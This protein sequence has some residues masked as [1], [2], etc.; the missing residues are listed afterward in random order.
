M[1]VINT[2]DGDTNA[3]WE[4][5]AGLDDLLVVRDLLVDLGGG[6]WHVHSDVELGDGD[7]KA[8]VVEELE[9]GLVVWDGA[10]A[11]DQVRLGSNTVDWDT[12][13]L[14]AVD[15]GDE[16]GEL[17]GGVV[18]VVVVEVEL[19]VWIGLG[20]GTESNLNG[21]LTEEAVEDGVTVVS[22]VLEDLVGDIP[23]L[24]LA[25]PARDEGGDVG[26]E[27]AGEGSGIVDVADPLWELGVPE[28]S[29]ATD[30]LAVLSGVVD[31]VVT[32]GKVEVAMGWLGR[33]PLHGV[34]WGEHTEL[35]LDDVV[36][37]ADGESVL[38][39]GGT[40]VVLALGSN[41]SMKSAWSGGWSSTWS[42]GGGRGWDWD[43]GGGAWNGSGGWNNGGGWDS[44]CG[45]S[46]GSSW[47]A[48]EVVV[49][50]LL[51]SSTRNAVGWSRVVNTTT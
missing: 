12:S 31:E 18:E 45:W 34:L 48:L 39:N 2:P 30:V 13:S 7:V 27:D 37:L 5:H 19:A 21:L 22:V 17:G 16:V 38:V 41:L 47:K 8:G 28:E 25:L 9:W 43:S 33:V 29:V 14:E 50:E 1:T 24:D 23:V 49:V 15:E 46:W 51:A 6:G 20:G 4:L 44:S 3:S 42:R 26:L 35:S 36:D 11:D 40:E 10:V 32:T